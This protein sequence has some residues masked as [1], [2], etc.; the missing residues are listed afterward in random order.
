MPLEK[1]QQ[2]LPQVT[3]NAAQDAAQDALAQVTQVQRNQGIQKRIVDKEAPTQPP[4][5]GITLK[6]GQTVDVPH[7]LGKVASS[8]SVASLINPMSNAAS[9]PSAAP[10]LQVIEMPGDVGKRMV[11]VRYLAP[12]DD[13]GKDLDTPQIRA[14]LELG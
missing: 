11:R 6:P 4:G 8:V 9:A 2:F 1:P 7:N 13:K 12:K 3:G 5:R 14:K 10:N